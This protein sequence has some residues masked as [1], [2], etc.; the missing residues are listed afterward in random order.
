MFS[1]CCSAAFRLNGSFV[2]QTESRAE[3]G[4]VSK[5]VEE[6]WRFALK[7]KGMKVSHSK[8][9]NMCM[10]EWS[11]EVTKVQDNLILWVHR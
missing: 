8:T 3:L 9:E 11:S 10:K 6:T 7:S 4:A 1:W 2:L 5:E